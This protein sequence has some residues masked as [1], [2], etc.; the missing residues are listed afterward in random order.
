MATSVTKCDEDLDISNCESRFVLRPVN[1]EARLTRVCSTMPL[2]S[3]STPRLALDVDLPEISLN[4]TKNQYNQLLHFGSE[5]AR[6]ET[7]KQ[8]RSGRPIASILEK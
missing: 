3:K 6:W 8:Y 5:V 1:G 4:L 7:R 2:R